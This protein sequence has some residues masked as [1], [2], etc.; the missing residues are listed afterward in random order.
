MLYEQRTF[1]LPASQNTSQ[2]R[3]DLATLTEEEFCHKYGITLS[4]Y[5]DILAEEAE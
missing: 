4:E 5:N 1:T 3:W 2:R